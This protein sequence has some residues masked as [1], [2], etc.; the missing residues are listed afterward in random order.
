AELGPAL[1][2]VRITATART[3]GKTGVEMEALT[4]VAAACLTVY[5]MVKSA[6]RAMRIE[7][8]RLLYKSGGRSGEYHAPP[9]ADRRNGGAT[10]NP[11]QREPRRRPQ[12]RRTPA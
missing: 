10:M 7:A 6:D 4:A 11:R 3:E 8:I 12:R 5:D 2:G 1:P 9:A